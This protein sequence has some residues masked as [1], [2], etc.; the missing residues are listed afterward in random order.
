MNLTKLE[1]LLRSRKLD[2]VVASARSMPVDRVAGT[3]VHS[4]DKCLGGGLP[5]G[6]LSEIVGPRS[7]G[8]A[9]VMCSV[10]AAATRRGEFVT[11]IDTFDS[12]DPVS[13]QAAGIDLSRVLWVRGQHVMYRHTS[14][15][16]KRA[17]KAANLVC[18]SGRFSVVVIDVAEASPGVLQRFPC[19]T[20]MRIARAIEGSTT[21]GL[22]VGPVAMGRSAK[23]GSIML[24]PARHASH[25]AEKTSRVFLKELTFDVR[26]V[27]ARYSSEPFRLCAES[28]PTVQGL[29]TTAG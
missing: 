6:H 12:F 7:S 29:R 4:L 8:R 18:Q 16:V 22:S 3:G 19:T 9:S 13:G 27:S 11:L 10:L 17:I 15:V 2:G 5:R 21:V 20:W 24:T 23:G 26:V 14:R 28:E 25:L 1:A